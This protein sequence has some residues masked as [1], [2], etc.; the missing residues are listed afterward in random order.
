[1]VSFVGTIG[2]VGLVAPHLSR[3]LVGEDQRFYLPM[4]TMMGA[5]VLTL[6][7]LV[8]KL[9]VPGTIIPIG[10]VTSLVGVPFL[11]YLLVSKRFT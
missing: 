7:S 8:S 5:L 11:L 6:A 9:V 10:I 2:F 1:A 3:M 4:A